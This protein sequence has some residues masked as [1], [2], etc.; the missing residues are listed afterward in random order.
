M[1]KITAAFDIIFHWCGVWAVMIFG[2]S[3]ALNASAAIRK[4]MF[5][6]H[7]ARPFRG[8]ELVGGVPLTESES[9]DTEGASHE[10]QAKK[11]RKNPVR[12][13]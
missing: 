11:A 3:F 6:R 13:K 7:T 2:T 9:P 5:R 1:E 8:K 12:P 4:R 10:H